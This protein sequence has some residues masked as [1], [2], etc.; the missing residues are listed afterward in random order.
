[1]LKIT[2][3]KIAKQ[4]PLQ[5][6]P[7]SSELVIICQLQSAIDIYANNLNYSSEQNTK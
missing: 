2:R 4:P 5:P 3:Q 1:M 7:I 6:H